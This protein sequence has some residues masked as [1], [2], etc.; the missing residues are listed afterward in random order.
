M[1]VRKTKK[2]AVEEK[3]DVVD[4]DT[5]SEAEADV[6]EARAAPGALNWLTGR[7]LTTQYR[8]M[9]AKWSVLPLYQDKPKLLNIV[10]SIRDKEALVVVSGTG[11]GKTVIVP[12]LALKHV[13]AAE[14]DALI[15]TFL[16]EGDGGTVSGRERDGGGGLVAVTNPKSSISLYNA[17]FA[18][19]T[20]DV[21]LGKEV[22]YAY[23][24]SGED[25][26]DASTRLLFTTDGYLVAHN[27][28]DPSFSK[29]DVIIV[30]EA[31]ERTV[32]IDVLLFMLRR[33]VQ[34]RRRAR[35][36]ASFTPGSVIPPARGELRVII[37]SATIDTSLFTGYF[38]M[39]GVNTSLV[40][41]S[42][43]TNKPVRSVFLP[44][45]SPS[46]V[47]VSAVRADGAVATQPQQQKSNDYIKGPGMRALR[48]AMETTPAGDNILFFVPT[49]RDADRGCQEV[50]AACGKGLLTSSPQDCERMQCTPLY[51]KLSKD[52]QDEAKSQT[53]ALPFDRR[54]IFATNIAES[55][56]TLPSLATV[57]DS[58]MELEST[59]VPEARATRMMKVMSTRAQMEQ[60]KG[61]VGR[62]RPGTCYH[63]YTER[64][65]LAQ[66]LYPA[67]SI[68]TMD[69][70][71]DVLTTSRDQG[72]FGKACLD[73]ARFITPPTAPQI[74]SAA[75]VLAFY[76]LM[77]V[78]PLENQKKEQPK[79]VK[80]T[81][82]GQRAG[83]TGTACPPLHFHDIDFRSMAASPGGVE[84]IGQRF[85]G[86][87]TPLGEVLLEVM[88]RCKLGLW[89]ALLVVA[90]FL[91]RGG[92]DIHEKITSEGGRGG[93]GG[94]HERHGQDHD[95]H[96]HHRRLPRHMAN[97]VTLASLL[98]ETSGDASML[99]YDETKAHV[100]L[101]G[102][103]ERLHKTSEH[104]SLLSLF[105]ELSGPNRKLHA[106]SRAV[107]N[108]MVHK[109]SVRIEDVSRA[110][111]PLMTS[112]L[113]R[114]VS[115]TVNPS[116][117]SIEQVG[118]LYGLNAVQKSVLWARSY[119]LA[120]R[121][122]ATS[123]AATRTL[124][125]P[126]TLTAID[127]PP[128][129]PGLIVTPP[130]AADSGKRKK[131]GT[132]KED[133]RSDAVLYESCMIGASG[134]KLKT[135]TL[136]PTDL[137]SKLML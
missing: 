25:S 110:V 91:F 83:G 108:S 93:G 77:T 8:E 136:F 13:V 57:I 114:A 33:A 40:E 79:T 69:L 39:E 99:W 111:Q 135:V 47:P 120:L 96:R 32:Y 103:Q 1:P 95:H 6:L 68:V 52:R 132:G 107:S 11:S 63:L 62:T 53:V 88:R 98:E 34:M 48:A 43:T 65:M 59:W 134:T 56:L 82:R 80:K 130:T 125:N 5:F 105:E 21:E 118:P 71:D 73:Y 70:T 121:Y 72:D 17:E 116:V 92:D 87:V 14:T 19:K 85:G 113:L 129:S 64:Q 74:A 41:V 3:V 128:P 78:Y 126:F 67:P 124:R 2:E 61:R 16:G 84:G 89:N 131:G 117:S 133:D 106:E 37:M 123:A 115:S 10:Q 46:D 30:D 24:G 50:K 15:N 137:F 22:G 31:H 102:M 45:S 35:A 54:V 86:R 38:E 29:Y 60:R 4:S 100:V 112:R 44:E 49:S 119:N 27:R 101:K 26:H 9:S 51:A 36:N 75:S 104:A 18:A 7:P 12:K 23:R 127:L 28:N 42:G 58:G 20:L 81:G 97:M 109:V 122:T 90:G 94:R 55:S 76:R 66:P